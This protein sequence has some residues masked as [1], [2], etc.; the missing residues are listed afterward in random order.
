LKVLPYF[1]FEISDIA[2]EWAQADQIRVFPT[3]HVFHCCRNYIPTMPDQNC[4]LVCYRSHWADFIIEKMKKARR[5][6]GVD[7]VYLDATA[8][9]EGC[10]NPRHGCGYVAKDGSRRPT[11]PFFAVRDLMKRM[12]EIFPEE[13]GGVIIAHSSACQTMPTLGFATSHWDAEHMVNMP[14]KSHPLETLPLAYFR[15]SFMGRNLGVPCTPIDCNNKTMATDQLLALSL[16][17]GVIP[18]MDLSLP[19]TKKIGVYYKLLRE[20]DADNAR[21][22]PYW[23]NGRYLTTSHTG[24]VY[25][26]FFA[27]G[28]KKEVLLFVANLGR[29]SLPSASVAIDFAAFGFLELRETTGSV[30]T[31]GDEAGKPIAVQNGKIELSLPVVSSRT[32]LVRSNKAN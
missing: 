14:A 2:P 27:N 6:Y 20:C 10:A 32:I 5:Q 9:P 22:L 24:K 11:Y 17:H 4:Y 18:R 30:W 3:T 8:T 16:L 15:A 26:S 1:G 12:W 28:G 21:W 13:Q 31:Y 23:N 19:T 29:E 25:A 7:G